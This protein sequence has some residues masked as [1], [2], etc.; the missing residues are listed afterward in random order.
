[1]TYAMRDHAETNSTDCSVNQ[2]KTVMVSR[3]LHTRVK[4]CFAGTLPVCGLLI[5]FKAVLLAYRALTRL[6]ALVFKVLL[7][8]T[9]SMQNTLISRA[10]TGRQVD[11][12]VRPVVPNR[13]AHPAIHRQTSLAVTTCRSANPRF[14]DNCCMAEPTKLIPR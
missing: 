12:T 8:I 4:S 11:G 1:M 5:A 7:P 14:V 13:G 3:S 9:E 10:P 6:F 2:C